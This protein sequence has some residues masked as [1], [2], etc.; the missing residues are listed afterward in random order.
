LYESV[1][2]RGYISVFYIKVGLPALATLTKVNIIPLDY[3]LDK[4]LEGLCDYPTSLQRRMSKKRAGS[5]KAKDE[6][7]IYA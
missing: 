6:F 5:S 2:L 7:S 1:Q 3:L 4:K